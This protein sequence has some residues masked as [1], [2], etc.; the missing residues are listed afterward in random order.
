M[1]VCECVP[2]FVC[3]FMWLCVFSCVCVRVS[4]GLVYGFTEGPVLS[5]MACMFSI[6]A[7]FCCARR[8]PC[9]R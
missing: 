7:G 5:A 4:V 2:V 3:V 6:F 1:S 8:A 9:V